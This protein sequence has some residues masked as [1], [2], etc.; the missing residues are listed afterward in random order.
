MSRLGLALVPLALLSVS[1]ANRPNQ[2]HPYL[3]GIAPFVGFRGPEGPGG[4]DIDLAP[5]GVYLGA[6]R[7]LSVNVSPSLVELYV[8][9]VA[10]GFEIG[11][12]REERREEEAPA[13]E[14]KPA[15]PQENPATRV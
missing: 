7:V 6:F 9:P 5:P 8:F 15:K 1:C 2:R 3:F 4:L 12:S 14:R 11:P 10:V 13:P